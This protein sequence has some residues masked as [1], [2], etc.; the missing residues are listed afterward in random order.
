MSRLVVPLAVCLG[1]LAAWGLVGLTDR[2]EPPLTIDDPDRDLGPTPLGDH[3]VRFAPHNPA[4][5]P[6]SVVGGGGGCG[7]NACLGPVQR[8][9]ADRLTV[10]AGGTADFVC[11]LSVKG[12]GPFEV[13]VVLFLDDNGLRRVQMTV[14]GVGVPPGAETPPH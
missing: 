7:R 14:R 1:G 4:A 11:E 9:H 2:A 12:E 5:R 3:T 8:D 10:P 6:R 13:P